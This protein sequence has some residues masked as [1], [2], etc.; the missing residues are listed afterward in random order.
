MGRRR[1]LKNKNKRREKKT[2]VVKGKF[3]FNLTLKSVSAGDFVLFL[4]APGWA[5]FFLAKNASL[6]ASEKQHSCLLQ[7]RQ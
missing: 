4:R 2:D 3:P 5:Q 7:V 1:T 6:E